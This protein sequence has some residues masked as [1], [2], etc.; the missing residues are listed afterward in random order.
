MENIIQVDYLSKSFGKATV[1]NNINVSFSKGQI[2]GI[3]GRNGS[4]KTLLMKCICGFLKPTEGTVTVSGKVVG[5]DVEI[6][7]DIGVIIETPGFVTNYSGYK[8]LKLLASVR[9]RISREDIEKAMEL[10]NLDPKSRKH[11]GK[12]SLGMRQRLGIAQAIMEN[13][14]I[15]ILD[16]PMNGLDNDGVKHIRNVLLE[17]KKQGTTILLASHNRE[18]ISVLC[19][20]VYEMDKGIIKEQKA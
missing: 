3:V 12:Y 9:G 10:V 7:E 4:G 11:V 17:M 6:P 1:L 14:K 2:H 19:D 18:N 5:K 13:P 20:K 8:N 16:E 15:L